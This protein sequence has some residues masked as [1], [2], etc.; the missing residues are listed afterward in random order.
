MLA[1]KIPDSGFAGRPSQPTGSAPSR[2]SS[3][4]GGGGDASGAPPAGSAG[5]D[6]PLTAP[7]IN[8]TAEAKRNYSR[9][10]TGRITSPLYDVREAEVVLIAET[11]RLPEIFNALARRNFMT[12][13]DV[14]VKPADAF[15]AAREGLVY[16]KAPV[17]EVTMK[18]ESVW[19]REWT[20][21][22]MPAEVRTALGVT[23]PAAGAADGD[24]P[25]VS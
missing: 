17:S 14:T 11:A 24:A 22:L 10:F 3:G 18:I 20:A 8:Q 15:E 4:F 23:A 7:V 6:Q 9:N 2:G 21:P 13:V 12:V 19:L 16:G 25:P 5:A 1:I